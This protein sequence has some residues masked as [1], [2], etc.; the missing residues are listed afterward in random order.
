LYTEIPEEEKERAVAY[1]IKSMPY[2]TFQRIDID[3]PEWQLDQ[4]F[5]LG[6]DVRNLLRHGGFDWDDVTLDGIWYKLFEESTRRL[7]DG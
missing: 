3:K 1:L 4:H 2:D 6:T 7:N 5:G